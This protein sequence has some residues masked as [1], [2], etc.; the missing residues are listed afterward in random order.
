MHQARPHLMHT[1]KE[2]YAFY[3]GR[4]GSLQK[5][6]EPICGGVRLT[7]LPL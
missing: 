3:T 6:S 2:L 5:N 7:D 4:G 1:T